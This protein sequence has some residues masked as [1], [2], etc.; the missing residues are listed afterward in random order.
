[1]TK[2]IAVATP[3][4]Q[5]S[6]WVAL[7]Y[8]WAL[9]LERFWC[10][11]LLCLLFR[12]NGA[13]SWF[14]YPV[15]HYRVCVCLPDIY[16]FFE[17]SSVDISHKYGC[18]CDLDSWNCQCELISIEKEKKTKTITEKRVTTKICLHFVSNKSKNE[19]RK[20]QQLRLNYNLGHINISHFN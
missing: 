18:K 13:F 2:I 16:D 1:M 15:G 4:S 9:D 6:F 12:E 5:V 19:K 14:W 7:G 11:S 10:F 3:K 17:Y 20:R 8:W